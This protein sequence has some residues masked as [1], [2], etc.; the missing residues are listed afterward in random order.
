MKEMNNY[1]RIFEMVSPAE[2]DDVFIKEIVRKVEQESMKK[3]EHSG[4]IRNP[5]Y[6]LSAALVLLVMIGAVGVFALALAGDDYYTD[7]NT[8]YN[9]LASN[10]TPENDN[11]PTTPAITEPLTAA[12]EPEA[13]S[14]SMPPDEPEADVTRHEG[15]DVDIVE[16]MQKGTTF[17]FEGRRIVLD[18]NNIVFINGIT[19]S[20]RGVL[21]GMTFEKGDYSTFSEESMLKNQVVFMRYDESGVTITLEG[22]LEAT[23]TTDLSNLNAFFLC[24]DF[25]TPISTEVLEEIEWVYVF[26][27][28]FVLNWDEVN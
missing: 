3:L 9:P 13:S 18:E 6:L 25:D 11:P 26:N 20:P 15:F 21:V 17:E 14:V 16:M 28:A 12:T 24:R 19:V 23:G 10:D 22:F 5:M 4:T 1:T 2:S 7:G 27:E 8:P